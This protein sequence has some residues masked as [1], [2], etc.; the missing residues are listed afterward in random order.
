ML[1]RL[2]RLTDECRRL[3][4]HYLFGS[5]GNLWPLADDVFGRSGVSGYYEVDR[6]AGMDIG[7][8]RRSHPQL[9]LVGAG[10]SSIT[11]D[12][13]SVQEVIEQTRDCIE[14]AR[15]CGRVIVGISNAIVPSTPPRNIDAMLETIQK[16]R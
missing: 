14:T 5:Y 16:H 1:P 4:V 10:I 11:L 6:L 13:G 12:R 15:S 9:T 3:D 2:R 7:R 8:L